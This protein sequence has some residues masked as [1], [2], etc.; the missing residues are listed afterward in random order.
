MHTSFTPPRKVIAA[1]VAV[2]IG[3]STGWALAARHQDPPN[4]DAPA[5]VAGDNSTSL[6]TVDTAG[7]VTDA[8][9]SPGNVRI[10]VDASLAGVD[11]TLLSDDGTHTTMA[12]DQL[13]VVAPDEQAFAAF[14]GRWPVT[15]LDR[16]R[17]SADG[18]FDAL[19]RLD[20]TVDTSRV[21]ADVAATEPEMS[22]EHRVSDER[23]LSLM[24]VSSAEALRGEVVVLPNFGTEGSG[25][26]AD[27]AIRADRSTE[28]APHKGS[29]SNPF[30]WSYLRDG[31]VQ[32]FGVV[33]AWNI[34]E[35]TDGF[36]RGVDIGIHDGGFIH[37]DD[38]GP[39]VTLR[40]AQWDESN[41]RT[42]TNGTPCPWHGTNVAQ[43]ALG[44]LDDGDGVAGPA[45]PIGQLTAIG[46]NEK[47]SYQRIRELTDV[48]YEEDVDIVNM[49]WGGTTKY[50]GTVSEWWL[51]RYFSTMSDDG[52]LLVAAAGNDGL[53]VD[54]VSNVCDAEGCREAAYSYPC[55]SSY[56]LCVG[57]VSW[58]SVD[59]H[60]DSNFGTQQGNRT[61]EIYG[62][63]EVYV[64]SIG[65]D[66]VVADTFER[67]S[68]TSYSAPFV[69]GIAALLKTPDLSITPRKMTDLLLGTARQVVSDVDI[70]SGHRRLVNARE[71]VAALRGVTTGVPTLTLDT[72]ADGTLLPSDGW[73]E[74]RAT[75]T[76]Y[77]GRPLSWFALAG[78]Q[79]LGT[80]EP[81]GFVPVQLPPGTHHVVVQ[82]EDY[83]GRQP[84]PIAVSVTVPDSPAELTI[85]GISDGDRFIAGQELQVVGTG[86]DPDDWTMLDDDQLVWALVAAGNEPVA[87]VEGGHSTIDLPDTPGTY[88]LVLAANGVAA[89]EASVSITLVAAPDGW[90][91]PVIQILEPVGG[92]RFATDGSQK[93]TFD[94]RGRAFRKGRPVP[95]TELRWVASADGADDVVICEG[96]AFHADPD[97]G[98]V[99]GPV[100]S[101]GTAQA[102]LGLGNA[103]GATVWT[104]RLE[105]FDPQVDITPAASVDVLV[106][107]IVG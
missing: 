96:A 29:D 105:V 45:G 64:S 24:A 80:T 10:V 37:L 9:T 21:E 23:V 28:D 22:G 62:P 70:R 57:G 53:D 94:V 30:E 39:F 31:S 60:P 58:D 90:V 14:V 95:A 19:V 100:A 102:T 35:H 82:T 92:T 17:A 73:L 48:A 41:S 43:V 106:E 76:D 71:A 5:D 93:V 91:A 42:C 55:E 2:V 49:S 3:A 32:D 103:V 107:Y 12:P 79:D 18:S 88:T 8:V 56:V 4:L 36:Q 72:P 65:D 25:E 20:A 51:D 1:V 78:G 63:Y 38:F 101:C 97:G 74:I 85:H 61:V 75:A 26:Q 87:I 6:P 99:A 67:G 84:A 27:Q 50:R 69:A 98:L 40:R 44:H 33:G 66:G 34:L 52:V 81:H 77:L 89:T 16:S 13:V 59:R 15:E 54:R 83:A 7:T 104:I 47:Y 86:Q 68:G 11:G 46:G